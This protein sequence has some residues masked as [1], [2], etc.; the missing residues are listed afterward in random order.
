MMRA[1]DRV[2]AKTMVMDMI[3]ADDLFRAPGIAMREV[4][5]PVMTMDLLEIAATHRPTETR[6][7]VVMDMGDIPPG[8]GLHA[9]GCK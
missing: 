4:G 7:R 6:H 9:R 8:I 5:V 2:M 1:E 3:T